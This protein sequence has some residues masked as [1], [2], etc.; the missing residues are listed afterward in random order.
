MDGN[1]VAIRNFTL[2]VEYSPHK[3]Y[4]KQGR[5]VYIYRDIRKTMSRKAVDFDEI[6]PEKENITISTEGKSATKLVKALAL[7]SR[8]QQLI[9]RQFESRIA[10]RDDDDDDV[11][12]LIHYI[13]YVE[14]LR[15]AYP[16]GLTSKQSGALGVIERCLM[17]FKD[18][19][20]YRDDI[21]YLKL[22]VSYIKDFHADSPVEARNLYVFM[23]RNKIGLKHELFYIEF[24]KL[25][26]EMKRFQEG[27]HV[28]KRGVKELST[29]AELRKEIEEYEVALN[30]MG[31][32]VVDDQL[33][34]LNDYFANTENPIILDRDRQSILKARQATKNDRHGSG[35]SNNN[36]KLQIFQDD[37][38][39]YD[40]SPSDLDSQPS[41]RELETKSSRRKENLL[42]KQS[43]IP[44]SD[45]NDPLV[46]R[47]AA[48]AV[49][50]GTD[51]MDTTKRVIFNDNLGRN[52]PI[53]TVVRLPN[54][55]TENLDYNV[56]LLYEDVDTF[57]IEQEYCIEE[58]LAIARGVYHNDNDGISN[59]NCRKRQRRE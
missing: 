22:W 13:E 31:I 4:L 11:D 20:R 21:R 6:E 38:N 5:T 1:Q 27:Y 12:P 49:V 52:G 44:N 24:S 48:V 34:Q 17:K 19:D 41:W 16:Q 39:L 9:K 8:E 59:G 58:L 46:D 45:P 15:H 35:N 51:R 40:Q 54:G 57:T 26:F 3:I 18:D 42:L 23:Y 53:Y 56:E 36:N 32:E 33:V 37:C 47:K 2:L 7:D 14:W 28:L 43:L 30:E 55:K 10:Q 29:A 50:V 25:L